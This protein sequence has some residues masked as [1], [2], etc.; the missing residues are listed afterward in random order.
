MGKN[1]ADELV[2]MMTPKRS[3]PKSTTNKNNKTKGD[4]SMK[5]TLITISLTALATLGIVYA[6]VYTYQAG[7]KAEA[8]R[9]AEVKAKIEAAVSRVELKN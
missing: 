2:N 3:K 7:A 6:F 4:S 1:T 8:N 5:R 9:Q